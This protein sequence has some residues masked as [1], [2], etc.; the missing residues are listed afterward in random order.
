MIALSISGLVITGLCIESASMTDF[1]IGKKRI[2][3]RNT[4][5]TTRGIDSDLHSTTPL[6]K[7]DKSKISFLDLPCEIRLLIYHLVHLSS[8]V[9]RPQTAPWYC[10]ST[11][12]TY[13]VQAIS[14]EDDGDESE[15]WSHFQHAKSKPLNLVGLLLPERPL[16]RIPTVLAQSC[17]QIHG[18]TRMIPFHENEFVFIN[19]FSLGLTSALAFMQDREPWQR[20]EMRYLR[21]EVFARDFVS[22]SAKFAAWVQLCG[23][24]PGLRGLRLMVYMEGGGAYQTPGTAVGPTG[25]G[26]VLANRKGI[27]N[28]Q[29]LVSERTEWIEEGLTRLGELRQLEV[30]LVDAKWAAREKVEWCGRLR[31][32]LG[33]SSN[34]R[35]EVKVVSVEKLGS[36]RAGP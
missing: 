4:A 1:S 29:E 23:N 33:V 25:A 30:E 27:A 19:W 22:G 21:L 14:A 24:L 7:K 18:E 6:Y 32:L 17:R 20:A 28:A 16:C 9:Q 26:T 11:C 5:L 31:E 35:K 36:R 13:T 2:Q 34:G 10:F 8:P 12:R 15:A 3:C